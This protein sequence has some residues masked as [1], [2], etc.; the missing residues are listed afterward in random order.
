MW[1][2]IRFRLTI[3]Y[4]LAFGLLLGSFSAYIYSQLSLDLRKQFDVSLSRT[5]QTTANTFI[6]FAE[7]KKISDGAEDTVSELRLENVSVAILQGQRVLAAS[8]SEIVDAIAAT[9]ILPHLTS[10]GPAV[11]ATE[12]NRKKRLVAMSFQ[13]DGVSYS[14]VMS[15]AL[16]GLMSQLARMRHIIL[17][18]LPAAL[19]LT[20][21]SGFML[22]KKSLAPVVT[23]SRQAEQISAKNL[24]ERLS[25]P[26]PKDELGQLASVFN[27]LLSRLDTSFRV[28]R[29]FIADA[30]HELRTPLA[31]IRAEAEVSLAQDRDIRDYKQSLELIEHQSQRMT[32]IVGDM[33]ALA[34][35]DV[36]QHRLQLEELYLND[37][38]DDC[39][40][41]AQ[42]LAASQ[43]V[44]LVFESGADI[45]VR[46]DEE[47]LKRM[48]VN[49]LDNAIHYTLSGGSI[50]VTLNA[51]A[52]T[53]RLTV[54]DTGIGIPPECSTRVFD[55]FYRVEP[56]RSRSQGGSGL[57][58]SIVKLAAEAHKGAV[59]L[60][61]KLGSGSTFTVTLPL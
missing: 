17:F 14:I 41:A 3:W 39:C 49:L 36:G 44:A 25:I 28:M 20:A 21:A 51:E 31:I 55:R 23:I 32:R 48:V 60:S 58:L 7:R 6:E 38:I 26:N 19:A 12:T 43:G 50:W 22:A 54:S 16:D 8:G 33:L 45:S 4:L 47:L 34:R 52:S 1:N 24:E 53:V 59:A 27:A 9:K 5:A 18:G 42:A 46:G 37:L 13:V 30:S 29:E 56:S 61:S 15:E 35:A 11:F 57:G 10:S 40:K 2:S